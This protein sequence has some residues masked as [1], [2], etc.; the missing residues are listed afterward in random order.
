MK[1]SLR[2]ISL[3]IAAVFLISGSMMVICSAAPGEEGG[4]VVE[5]AEGDNSGSGNSGEQQGSGDSG[6]QGGSGDSGEQ[7]SGD[8][9][10]GE[11]GSGEQGS[12]EQGGSDHSGNDQSG[13]DN[14]SNEGG[15]SD[16][17]S[18]VEDS[19]PLFY[20]DASNYSYN[21]TDNSGDNTAGAVS[22]NTPLYNSSGMS[23]ADAAPNEWSDIVLD[24]KTVKTGVADF[25]AIKSNT[26]KQDNGD[27]ILYLGY[28]LIGLSVLG[29]LYFIIATI[30]H[31]KAMQKAER[32]ERRRASAP[33]RSEAARMEARE[34][35]AAEPVGR[36]TSRFADEA[37]GYSRR[38]SSKADTGE[39]YVPRRAAKRS[40]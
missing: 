25:S 3:I 38:A 15:Y 39:V 24:E 19:D 9:G 12:G 21:I 5:P 35:R 2:L 31:R 17:N 18:Y 11:Q 29:I 36:R 32:L 10:S 16:N 26:E 13:Y 23:A 1:K 20:G 4:A 6:E 7:G 22:S 37:P 30:S 33:A 34:R 27:W 28:A 14:N 8:Q 40:R